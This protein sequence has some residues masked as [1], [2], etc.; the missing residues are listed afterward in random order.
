MPR[1]HI[2]QSWV[3]AAEYDE[4]DSYNGQQIGN[5]NQK[6]VGVH[7]LR[8]GDQW[9]ANISAYADEQPKKKTAKKKSAFEQADLANRHYERLEKISCDLDAEL[10]RGEITASQWAMARKQLDK[11]LDRAWQRVADANGWDAQE[12]DQE[13]Y[14]LCLS[15][16]QEKHKQKRT[17]KS[18]DNQQE[19]GLSFSHE[20][21]D[22]LSEENCFKLP[23]QK[24]L[25]AKAKMVKI[26]EILKS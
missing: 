18:I 22:S 16:M 10:D 12:K 23:L 24:L 1:T 17:Q 4:G 20:L 5:R 8:S 13:L 3:G 15:E 9:K 19:Q 26:L 6:S 11:R 21:I 25:T 2:L 7:I 14:S